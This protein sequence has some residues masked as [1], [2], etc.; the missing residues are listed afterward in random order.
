MA[1]VAPSSAALAAAMIAPVPRTG[2][3]V[4]VELGPG[5]GAFTAALHRRL[6]DRGRHLAVEINPA[7]AAALAVRFPRVDVVAAAAA[8][9]PAILADRGITAADVVVSGLPWAA[10]AGPVGGRLVDTIAT[11]LDPAGVF[12]QFTYTW[13]RWAPPARR[14]LGRLRSSYDEVLVGR[15]IWRNLPPAL[16]YIARRPHVQ[17]QP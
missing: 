10:Y 11:A 3:P 14:Q 2:D 17:G 7:M 16:A 4:V 13:S 12:T 15:T 9:L 8:D 6:G 5:T 1:S